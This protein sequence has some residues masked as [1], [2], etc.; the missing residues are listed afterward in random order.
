MNEM[1]AFYALRDDLRALRDVL[2]ALRAEIT[3]APPAGDDLPW[4]TR[5]VRNVLPAL[6]LPLPVLL[7]AICG[8]GSTGK[9][10]LFNVLAGRDL[11]RVGFRAGL[12]LRVLLAGHPD[13]LSGPEVAASL[14][15]RLE[16][17]PEPW[18][19]ADDAVTPG[20]PL[21]AAAAS[22][23]RNLLLID[24][25]D[26]DTGV[27][28]R[29]LNRERA[30]PVLRTAEVIVYVFTNAVYNNLSNTRF[31]ADVVGAIGG[32]PMVLVYRV[33]R[34]AD[35]AEVLEHCGVVARH[36]YRTVQGRAL[37]SEIL[38]IYRMHESDAV[39][40]GEAQ[41][42]IL[43]VGDVTGGRSIQEL[44]ATLDV[45]RIKRRVLAADLAQIRQEAA[46]EVRALR[47]ATRR[48]TLYRRGLEQVTA[49][50]ALGALRTFPMNEAVA[51]TTRLF[52]ASSPPHVKV[53]RATG[54]IA[55]APQRGAQAIGRALGRL[56]G[57]VPEETATP[58]P[59]AEL[60]RDLLNA[61]NALRNRLL[62][63]HL[64]VRV[65]DGDPLLREARVVAAEEH[66]AAQ[67]EA[68]GGG[69]FNVHLRA[70]DAVRAQEGELLAQD[71]AAVTHDLRTVAHGLVGLPA[72]IEEDL[73]AIVERFRAGMGWRE[74]LR[75]GF[76]ASLTALPPLLGVTYMLL[77]ANPVVGTGLWIELQ[78]LFGVNDL[79]ALVSIPASAG[80]GEQE[81]KQLQ[82][83][84]APAFRLWFERRLTTVVSVLQ[85]AVCRPALEALDGISA[86]DDA[87][88]DR[89]ARA[90]AA[91]E[92]P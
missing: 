34:A 3:G 43:P 2:P 15:H 66:D 27:A 74:R 30:E 42:S 71:W 41:P 88:F 47:G 37:P 63:D 84:V 40:L 92:V 86:P 53:L 58:D 13:V 70:P 10:T 80:L 56:M 52:L 7:V 32:R 22:V 21:F 61:A 82:Q 24:T 73:A 51:L 89:V 11:S 19:A 5:L 65:T 62:D 50:E 16:Q 33:S 36:L 75:E 31:V 78:G 85:S 48:A 67:V 46:A 57:E 9:S 81:R 79:W 76:F 72:D 87:R 23:P 12:T 17:A 35:D 4:R 69:V 44:L 14:L 1:N 28:G 83:M 45:A 29:L 55:A 68:L 90:L 8:G 54:R 38:G 20:P 39:A 49:Q 77:T 64:I 26:F 59:T 25:P 18:S 91:L 60:E 6:D